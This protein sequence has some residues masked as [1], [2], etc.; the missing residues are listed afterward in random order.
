[1]SRP[2]IERVVLRIARGLLWHHYRVTL[3]ATSTAF[4][5]WKDP[6]VL[7]IQAMLTE[8]TVLSSMGGEVFRYR[9]GVAVENPL[10][11]L[12]WMSFY[13]KTHFLIIVDGTTYGLVIPGN[14]GTKT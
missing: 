8:D 9:H 7:P 1:M 6:D 14:E 2:R 12:W 3:P 11:S 10:T 13:A 4:N 5:C